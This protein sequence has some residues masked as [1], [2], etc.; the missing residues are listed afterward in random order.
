MS[1]KK[2]IA[3]RFELIDLL[4]R[5]GMGDVY[6]G[7]DTQTDDFVAVKILHT[8]IVQE[9][10]QLVDR[11]EREG[12]ALRKLNH[13]NIVKVLA[14]IQE[15]NRHYLIMEFV[16]GGSLRDQLDA[17]ES[18]PVEQVLNVALDLCDALTRAHRMNII[19]RDIKPDNVLLAED[20]TP[21]LTDFGVAHLGDRTRLTQTGSVI[22]TYA[23]LSPEACNGLDL[24]ER[25]DIWSFGVM[26]FE[27]LA[28]R[29]PFDETSTAAML[30][31]ILTKPTPDIARLRPDIPSELAHLISS[32]LEKDRDR[33][34]SSVR[35]VGAEIEAL[36]RGS[37]TPL[38]A[39]LADEPR[40][41]STPIDRLSRGLER[42]TH[43]LDDIFPTP[44]G[45]TPLPTPLTPGTITPAGVVTASGEIIPIHRS[46][47]PWIALM[48]SVLAVA[49]VAIFALGLIFDRS[50]DDKSPSHPTSVAVVS[51]P[52]PI[53]YPEGNYLVLVAGFEQNSPTERPISRLLQNDLD[54]QLVLDAPYSRVSVESYPG[55]ITSNEEARAATAASGATV[56]VW[57]SYTRDS[58]DVHIEVGQTN[59]FPRMQMEYSVVERTTGIQV[60][61]RDPQGESVARQVLA[62][63]AGLHLAN[64]D[65]YDYMRT[66]AV[67]A[68]LTKPSP[69]IEGETVAAHYHRYFVSIFT[70]PAL[71]QQE[72]TNAQATEASN[73]LIYGLRIIALLR[74]GDFDA[75]RRDAETAARLTLNWPI[76][77]YLLGFVLPDE[78]I[79]YFTN[80]IKMQP[81]DWYAY[82]LRGA[83]YY[84]QGRYDQAMSD[85]ATSIELNPD[86]SLPYAY[87]GLTAIVQGQM[88]TASTMIEGLLSRF[89]E[90]DLYYR[91]IS[92][93]FGDQFLG[94]PAVVSIF[95][96][97]SLARY[98]EALKATEIG[99]AALGPQA[100]LY[101]LQGYAYCN[102]GD[103]AAA[104]QAYTRAIE[105]ENAQPMLF[106]YL[107]RADSRLQMGDTAGADEDLAAFTAALPDEGP[108]M[109]ESFRSGQA[110]CA[111]IFGSA[112][113]VD[114]QPGIAATA[115]ATPEPIPTAVTAAVQPVNPDEYMILVANLEPV[116]GAAERD[117]T[118]F[119]VDELTQTLEV[120]VPFSNIR[121]RTFPAIIRSDAEAHAAAEATGATVVVWGNYS[122]TLIELDIQIGVT[123]QFTY[124]TMDR[125]LLER[126]ANVR[127]QL[128]DERQQSIAPFVI[129]VVGILEIADGNGYESMR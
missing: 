49:C 86:S 81:D 97:V 128:T 91:V 112:T 15:E 64:G 70:D 102:L 56:I 63:L 34:I 51:S 92:A 61:L 78:S 20:G 99:L 9:N 84:H 125:G 31:A 74:Q 50:S 19:H 113:A 95:T 53:P 11:F 110:N 29:L 48:V 45:S 71:A 105:L 52:T 118:R 129:G 67:M 39:L 101:T 76:P 66:L 23:Y 62:T 41:A 30:T 122:P 37:D 8:Q 100:D 42:L 93:A 59:A 24:D 85:F 58:I 127:V 43:G 25:A 117:V 90:P 46:K 120:G 68:D 57:G 108:L 98:N 77:S 114:N 21:R 44:T 72:M 83:S 2:L 26:L 54:Q 111:N 3:G 12:E 89:P 75:A 80:V 5:G 116:G 35:V 103:Y 4:G 88:D 106:T 121:L 16:G 33:R 79:D 96:N 94:Q 28:G 123:T 69:A 104:D 1:E 115:A 119:I 6:R 109:A 60:S 17:Q 13:P 18:L 27:M 36:I 7:R 47:W 87:A 65:L 73:P 55:I 10:P 126:T 124:L 38:R 40:F 107:L 22:G 82:A 14:T 32:M